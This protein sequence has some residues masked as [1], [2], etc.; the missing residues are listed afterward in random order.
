[1]PVTLEVENLGNGKDPW[2]NQRVG[3]LATAR[4]DRREFGLGW[5]QALE[6]GGVLVSEN[7]DIEINVQ[8]VSD[9]AQAK[10]AG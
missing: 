5:N 9:S 7:I 10:K 1:K 8:A 2:G 3:F 4:I 6:A